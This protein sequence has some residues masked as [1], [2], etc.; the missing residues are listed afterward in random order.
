[1]AWTYHDYG[2]QVTAALRLARLRQ[3]ITE[4]NAKIQAQ[5]TGVEGGS[6]ESGDLVNYRRQLLE[7]AKELEVLA[8]TVDSDSPRA[9][10]GFTRGRPL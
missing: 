3:H 4:V 10:A 8:G 9:T 5:L 1:M 7:E 6:R 2:E